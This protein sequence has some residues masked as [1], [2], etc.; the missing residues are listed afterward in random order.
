MPASPTHKTARERAREEI[1][2]E[3][4]A[5]ARSQLAEAGAAGLSLRSLARELGMVSSAV[6]RYFPSRDA[7]LTRLIIDAYD[8]LG[9]VAEAAS[10]AGAGD[11]EG[12]AARW[13]ATA[14]AIR[15]WALRHPHD[16]ALLYGSP[17]PGYAAPDDTVGP[18]IRPALALVA[19]VAEAAATDRLAEP[20]SG[21]ALPGPLAGQLA[22]LAATVGAEVSAET[23]AR[24]LI[25]WTQLFGLLSFEL[26][27]QTRGMVSDNGALFDATVARLAHDLGLR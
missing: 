18:G 26:F 19:V 12:D 2:A 14:Q 11:G 16:F 15:S 22:T 6:Y 21:P 3:L 5:A 23:V 4:L 25:A 9:E 8:A 24:L 13:L 27:N 20:A 7:L 10:S 17:V 1:R